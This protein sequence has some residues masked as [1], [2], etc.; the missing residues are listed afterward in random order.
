MCCSLADS[1]I[2]GFG[3]GW[4][5]AGVVLVAGYGLYKVE[6]SSAAKDPEKKSP[7]T[8][9]I[10]GYMTPPEEVKAA[11]NHILATVSKMAGDKLLFAEA[12][13]PAI[14][15]LTYPE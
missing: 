4:I 1:D 3:T 8:R 15:R 9:Y 10:E 13:R 11:N 6:R 12:K 5:Q 7:I 2:I 14:H